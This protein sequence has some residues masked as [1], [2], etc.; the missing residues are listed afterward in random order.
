LRQVLA[1]PRPGVR[2]ATI[3]GLAVG[4]VALCALG[5]TLDGV[6]MMPGQNLSAAA[7]A[8]LGE[9]VLKSASDAEE[10]RITLF[11]P[12]THAAASVSPLGVQDLFPDN[13]YRVLAQGR[14]LGILTGTILFGLAFATLSSQRS[15]MLNN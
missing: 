9:L 8:Q 10:M 1:L 5:G 6:L 11:A 14:S 13:F 4:L 3:A 7:H 2:V 12:L 15:Q